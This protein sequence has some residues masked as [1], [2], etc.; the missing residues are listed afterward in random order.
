MAFSS[1][2]ASLEEHFDK[3]TLRAAHHLEFNSRTQGSEVI[4]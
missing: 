3:G 1:V 4:E 2:V